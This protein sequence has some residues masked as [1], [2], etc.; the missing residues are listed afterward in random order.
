M[1]DALLD[2]LAAMD[3]AVVALNMRSENEL[4]VVPEIF[5]KEELPYGGGFSVTVE[6]A[7]SRLRDAEAQVV[8][9]AFPSYVAEFDLLLGRIVRMLRDIEIDTSDPDEADL[10]ISSK[11]PHLRQHAGIAIDPVHELLWE[12]LVSIRNSVAHHGASEAPVVSAWRRCARTFKG[13]TETAQELW[14][15]L[16]ERP[17]PLT[18][19]SRLQFGDREV[20]G[21]Q[22]VLDSIAIDLASQLRARLSPLSWAQLLIRDEQARSLWILNMQDRNVKEV[23]AWLQ[24]GWGVGLDEATAREALKSLG[25]PV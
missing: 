1:D 25:H 15:R 12:L 6:A 4:D 21:C 7:R 5:S 8:L 22:R 3:L 24:Q 13:S 17:L 2:S 20:V 11:F 19:A 18:A 14:T 9:N 10:G 23:R 16:A